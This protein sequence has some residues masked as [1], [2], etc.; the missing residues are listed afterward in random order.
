MLCDRDLMLHDIV[1]HDLPLFIVVG[2]GCFQFSFSYLP[3][4]SVVCASVC[5]VSITGISDEHVSS[6]MDK[7]S[8][9]HCLLNDGDTGRTSPNAIASFHI[10]KHGNEVFSSAVRTYGFPY[11][12]VQ[13]VCGLSDDVELP[14]SAPSQQQVDLSAECVEVVMNKLKNRFKAQANL[15]AQVVSLTDGC[16]MLHEPGKEHVPIRNKLVKWKH[17]PVA[18][19]Q[20]KSGQCIVSIT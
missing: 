6:H 11:K 3:H 12:W 15:L 19:V 14:I 10:R 1:L 17:I 16:K 5:S 2:F 7:I 13:N 18:E 8:L 4:F 9:L 20:V